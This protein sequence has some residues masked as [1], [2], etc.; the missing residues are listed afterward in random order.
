M[1]DAEACLNG[2]IALLAAAFRTKRT[3]CK[4]R[5]VKQVRRILAGGVDCILRLNVNWISIEGARSPVICIILRL[6]QYSANFDGSCHH[7]N[8]SLNSA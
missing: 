3:T 1:N 6:S 5:Y 2:G 4:F 8:S 7:L